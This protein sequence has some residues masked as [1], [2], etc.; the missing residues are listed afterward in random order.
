MSL[1]FDREAVYAC[2]MRTT[3]GE[4][5]SENGLASKMRIFH[6]INSNNSSS[7]SS[8][9]GAE[10]KTSDNWVRERKKCRQ[11]VKIYV[12]WIDLNVTGIL[13][14]F[15]FLFVNYL[16][17]CRKEY[18][19]RNQLIVHHNSIKPGKK[20]AANRLH[21][22]VRYE[23]AQ[24]EQAIAL[25]RTSKYTHRCITLWHAIGKLA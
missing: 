24:Q 17:A 21:F 25:T 3:T 4:W 11:G 16:C 15:Q 14:L 9:K 8:K 22:S 1:H 13:S 6:S 23:F 5:L 2:E 12:N 7:S 18:A 19:R 20:T 10:Q